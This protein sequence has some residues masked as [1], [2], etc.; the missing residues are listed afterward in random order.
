MTTHTWGDD[1]RGRRVHGEDLY[2]PD[3]HRARSP[4][5]L[6]R[7]R[8]PAGTPVIG[9]DGTKYQTVVRYDTDAGI[10]RTTVI[11]YNGNLFIYHFT[12]DGRPTTGV[13]IVPDGTVTQTVE[14]GGILARSSSAASGCDK[15]VIC[16]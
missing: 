9:A 7:R 11:A 2:P 10:Y 12:F 4:G 5:F 14:T 3:Q 1:N 15:S 6:H 13:H 16:T 8:I